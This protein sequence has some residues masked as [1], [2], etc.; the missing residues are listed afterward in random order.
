MPH[1]DKTLKMNDLI[2]F[3]NLGVESVPQ[4]SGANQS[5]PAH[6]STIK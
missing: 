2:G 6:Q 3:L 5:L 4:G 1:I